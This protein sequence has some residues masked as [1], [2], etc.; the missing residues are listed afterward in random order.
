MLILTSNGLSSDKLR[1]EAKPFITGQKAALVMTADNEYKEKN[2]HVER[3]TAELNLLGAAIDIFDFDLRQPSELNEYGV[4]EMIGGNPFYLL[5]SIRVHGFT[6][7]LR[8]F[9]ENKCVIGCSAGS[10]VMTK[11]LE[12]ISMY[13]PEM[14]FVGMTDLRALS[15]TDVE[16]LPHYSR[17]IKR[18][19]DFEL[20]CVG[21]EQKR[22]IS[23]VR[24]NDGDAVIVIDVKHITVEGG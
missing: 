5:N 24:L 9:A 7:A 12:L 14:N 10:I 21:Y 11:S 18:I 2:Y 20:K 15:L 8:A 23:V 17:F 16:V 13:S 4:I 6:E 22:G 19:P 3:L 1:N